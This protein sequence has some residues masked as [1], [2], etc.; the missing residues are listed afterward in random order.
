[1]KILLIHS[2]KD[3]TLVRH[4]CPFLQKVKAPFNVLPVQQLNSTDGDIKKQFADFF[5]TANFSEKDI[6]PSN[7][8]THLFVVSPIAQRWLD[9]LAGFSYG[10]NLPLIIYGAKAIAAVPVEFSSFFRLLNS[11]KSLEEYISAE[12]EASEKWKSASVVIQARNTLLQMGIPVTGESLSVCTGEGSEREVSL[13]LAAGF[14]PDT[15]NKAG[16]PLLNI[17]ARSGSKEILRLLISSGAQINLQAEDRGTSALIDSAMQKNIDMVRTL[18][19]AGADLNIVSKDGQT[20]LIVAVGIGD[21]KVV[22]ALLKAGANPDIKDSMGVSA[23]KYAELFH[24]D[25]ITS[26]FQTYA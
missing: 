22:E 17:A 24:I 14:S 3:D 15:R 13:F 16:T 21:T 12:T 23:R 25:D 6:T 18:I 2:E 9:F 5:S 11:Q 19:D 4:I 20:A 8:L 1:M 7:T 10:S 26:L